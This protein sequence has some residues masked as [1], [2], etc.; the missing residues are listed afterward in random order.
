[1]QLTTILVVIVGLERLVAKS[2]SSLQLRVMSALVL[3]P[4]A[5]AAVYFGELYFTVFMT[6]AGL[7]MIYEW[8]KTSFK[9]N[10][11]LYGALIGV[12]LLVSIYLQSE[13]NLL[14]A[15]YPLYISA[16][17]I[18]V[19]GLFSKRDNE[20]LGGFLGPL[21]I[22]IPVLCFLQLRTLD[23]DGLGLTILLFAIVWATDTGAYFAGRRIGGPK[24]AVSISPNKT[25]AGLIGGMISAAIVAGVSTLYIDFSGFP[26][27]LVALLGAAFAVLAQ[28]G[29]FFE[30][31][32][33]RYFGIKDASNMIPGH[34][35]VLDRLDGVLF[36][37]PALYSM[38]MVVRM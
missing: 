7:A 26:V 37:A 20:W 11:Y 32:W 18:L 25:W 5:I 16:S 34:G 4:I 13:K 17:I 19:V 22:G 33:K 38:A 14:T 36:V 12:S 9:N 24:I 15:L 23:P 6:V 29:D 30:S 21:Y 27:W 28:I 3:A 1:M 8:C 31:G 10:G 2:Y 35:G